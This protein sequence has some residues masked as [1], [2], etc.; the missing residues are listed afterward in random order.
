MYLASLLLI[1][2]RN[3][4]QIYLNIFHIG[5]YITIK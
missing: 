1:P 3:M 5:Y 4:A 2:L